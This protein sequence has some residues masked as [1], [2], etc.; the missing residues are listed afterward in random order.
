MPTRW[1]PNTYVMIS[2][3]RE[4]DAL[5][6]FAGPEWNVAMI[7]AGMERFGKIYSLEHYVINDDPALVP[8]IPADSR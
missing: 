5:A 8:R 3:W 4:D 2:R 6:A 7:S 1:S